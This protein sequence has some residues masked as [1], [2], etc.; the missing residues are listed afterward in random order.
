MRNVFVKVWFSHSYNL[1]NRLN[2][3]FMT[4]KTNDFIKKTKLME[5]KQGEQNKW[6]KTLMSTT[7]IWIEV[8]KFSHNHSGL[9]IFP[10]S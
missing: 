10:L 6:T 7:R 4:L 1:H 9:A 8:P 3:Q 5:A 2:H